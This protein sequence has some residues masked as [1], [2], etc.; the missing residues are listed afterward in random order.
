MAIKPLK[1]GYFEL[2][3]AIIHTF[4][5]IRMKMKN[6]NFSLISFVFI[7]VEMIIV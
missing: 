4:Q 7:M 5:N 3:S 2:I 6:L 1:Y